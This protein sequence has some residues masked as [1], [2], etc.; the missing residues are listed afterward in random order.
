MR[1][2]MILS[3]RSVTF[4][5]GL[6][7]ASL[8]AAGQVR[9]E[10][11]QKNEAAFRAAVARYDSG[12]TREALVGFDRCITEFPAGHR[13]TAAYVMKGKALYRLGENLDAAKTLKAFLSR[14]PVSS[15]VPDAQLTLGTAK[16][17]ARL[18]NL[19]SQVSA[20][21][22]SAAAQADDLAKQ[23]RG[24][25]GKSATGGAAPRKA[26]KQQAFD[27]AAAPVKGW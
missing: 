16:E 22:P 18:S 25:L 2:P 19:A 12:F 26:A 11:S 3:L 15:Y 23:W 17:E 21:R 27:S 14:Y 20:D 10:F 1:E 4:F 8:P 7:M 5:T 13:V 9:L 6:L 24:M